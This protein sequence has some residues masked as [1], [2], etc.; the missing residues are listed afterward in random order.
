MKTWW[1]DWRLRRRRRLS[2][3]KCWR[4]RRWDS[5]HP[6]LTRPLTE[7]SPSTPNRPVS[8]HDAY[9]AL[10]RPSASTSTARIASAH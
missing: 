2:C 5:F 7:R 1:R 8:A 3:A 9:E 4:R 10:I 6:P